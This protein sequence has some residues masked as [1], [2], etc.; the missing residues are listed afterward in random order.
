LNESTFLDPKFVKN[1]LTACA[2]TVYVN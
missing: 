1:D 2:N